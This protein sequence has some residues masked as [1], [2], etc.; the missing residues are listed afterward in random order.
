MV[1][2]LNLIPDAYLVN[3]FL[4]ATTVVVLT[5]GIIGI[6][7]YHKLAYISLPSIF[8]VDASLIVLSKLLVLPAWINL[9]YDGILVIILGLAVLEFLK[10]AEIEKARNRNANNFLGNAAYDYYYSTN[11]KDKIVDASD[12]FMELV[13]LD[14]NELRKSKGFQTM[15]GE[16]KIQ[17]VNGRDVTEEIALKLFFDYDKGRAS[18]ETYQFDL[19]VLIDNEVVFLKGVVQ[20]IHYRGKFIG[21]NVYLIND[22]SATFDSLRGTIKGM[23]KELEDASRQTYAL[24]SLTKNAIMY[25][26]YKTGT[27]VATE[28]MNN[29]LEVTQ[30]EFTIEEFFDMIHPEDLRSYQEQGSMINSMMANRSKLRLYINKKYYD[31]YDDSLYLNKDSGL[32]SIISLVSDPEVVSVKHQ[33]EVKNA[34]MWATLEEINPSD[35]MDDLMNELKDKNNE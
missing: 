31:V 16:L 4:V 19:Q 1:N 11:S 34:N 3:L 24:M 7:V 12:T 27:Y 26:D 30:K 23:V 35:V 21:R 15:F 32:V 10:A 28:A 18:N 6:C 25:F 13:S 8:V 29:Y 2:I 20:P 22:K 9:I 17:K 33:Q 14:L 5:L